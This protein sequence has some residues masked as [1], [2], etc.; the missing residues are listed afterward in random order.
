M[1]NSSRGE[2]DGDEDRDELRQPEGRGVKDRSGEGATGNKTIETV[3]FALSPNP[4]FKPALDE[5]LVTETF[6]GFCLC[7]PDSLRPY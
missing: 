7:S 6:L 3:S 2:P 5:K 1:N 4:L